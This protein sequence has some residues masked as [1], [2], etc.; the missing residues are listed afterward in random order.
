MQ[1]DQLGISVIA[2]HL[3]EYGSVRVLAP[4]CDGLKRTGPGA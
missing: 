1:M 4:H 3:E 2:L